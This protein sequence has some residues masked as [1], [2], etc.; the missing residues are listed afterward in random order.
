MY[1][2][3]YIWIF[4][5]P[6]HHRDSTA[7]SDKG[8]TTREEERT[9]A[10]SAERIASTPDADTAPSEPGPRSKK[11]VK[12]V[13]DS[14]SDRFVWSVISIVVLVRVIGLNFYGSVINL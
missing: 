14:D 3:I 4:L 9:P 11:R 7:K 1:I 10:E 5:C 13:M 8:E 12:R 6:G 2:Y